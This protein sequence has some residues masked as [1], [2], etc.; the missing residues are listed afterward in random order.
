MTLHPMK[1]LLKLHTFNDSS[2]FD[3]SSSLTKW[4]CFYPECHRDDDPNQLI[5]SV[6]N[7]CSIKFHKHFL[8][9]YNDDSKCSK[10]SDLC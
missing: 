3:S 4:K 6:S 10:M 1:D 2:N 9:Y 5:T 7:E 8:Y